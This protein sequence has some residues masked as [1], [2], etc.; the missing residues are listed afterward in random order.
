MLSKTLKYF[1]LLMVVAFAVV[2]VYGWLNTSMS[3]D[4]ARQQQKTERERNELLR[5]F[6]QKLNR[7][8]TRA[9]I[10]QLVDQSFRKGHV[11]KEEQDRVLVD[12]IVFRFANDQSLVGVQFLGT[13][14]D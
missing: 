11:I 7:G 13:E 9:E 3:L 12:D 1:L 8:T 5:D 6:V 2:A 10:M 14:N 4:Y